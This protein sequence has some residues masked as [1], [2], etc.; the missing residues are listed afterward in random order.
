MKENGSSKV[1]L[2]DR[3]Q[4][5]KVSTVRTPGGHFAWRNLLDWG[6]WREVGEGGGSL[7]SSKGVPRSP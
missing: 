2:D 5:K 4:E 3:R 7:E 1:R 6:L